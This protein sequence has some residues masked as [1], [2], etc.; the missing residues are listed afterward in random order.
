MAEVRLNV[1]KQKKGELIA[2]QILEE[3]APSVS[4]LSSSMG[5]EVNNASGVSFSSFSIPNAGVE[6]KVVATAISVEENTMSKPI[7]GT[8]GFYV[9][10]VT[11]ISEPEVSDEKIAMEKSRLIR[12]KEARANVEPIEALKEQANIV[13]ERAKFF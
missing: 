9:I 4:S 8:N 13:D 6:P 2:Q 10:S 11:N 3:N 1:L 12:A 5:L 7:I